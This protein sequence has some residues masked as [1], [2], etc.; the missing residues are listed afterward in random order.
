MSGAPQGACP[1]HLMGASM[2]AASGQACLRSGPAL[3]ALPARPAAERRG[4]PCRG[5]RL[6]AARCSEHQPLDEALSAAASRRALLLAGSSLAFGQALS[7]SMRAL[8]GVCC[9]PGLFSSAVYHV[10][11]SCMV[12]VFTFDWACSRRPATPAGATQRGGGWGGHV[13]LGKPG[14]EIDISRAVFV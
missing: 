13:E 7:P 6:R 8:A 9:L 14:A 11:A 12:R 1:S 3:P 10:S 4:A 2:F 5:R